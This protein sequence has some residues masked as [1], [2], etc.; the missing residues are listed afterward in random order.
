MTVEFELKGQPYTALN[1]GPI[2]K[3]NE[4]VSFQVLCDT[5]EEIDHYWNKLLEGGG[6]ESVCG[7]LKDKF[8]LSWQ[9]APVVLQ[10]LLNDPERADRVTKVYLQMKKFDIEKLLKA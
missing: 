8:G 4:S 9:V 3:F 7:W 2:F 6:E 10:E 5:Q 1:G